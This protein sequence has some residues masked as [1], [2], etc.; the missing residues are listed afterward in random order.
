MF[1]CMNVG[2][3]FAFGATYPL[4][5]VHMTFIMYIA[6][7]LL[8]FFSFF[9]SPRSDGYNGMTNLFS[10]SIASYDVP[11]IQTLSL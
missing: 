2:W 6:Y 7:T 4:A 1:V 11:S 5:F 9:F 8:F 10:T 3:C